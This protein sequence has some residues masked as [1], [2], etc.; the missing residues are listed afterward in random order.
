MQFRRRKPVLNWA[1][2]R[3][4]RP[5]AGKWLQSGRAEATVPGGGEGFFEVVQQFVGVARFLFGSQLLV[6]AQCVDRTRHVI[7]DG[8]DEGQVEVNVDVTGAINA[9]SKYQ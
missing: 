6:L 2:E 7:V 4:D 9:L 3:Q 5:T 1:S 8:L